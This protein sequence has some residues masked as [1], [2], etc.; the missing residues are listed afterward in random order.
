MSITQRKRWAQWLK[1]AWGCW[2]I[3][4]NLHWIW[5]PQNACYSIVFQLTKI[6]AFFLSV[7]FIQKIAATNR[8]RRDTFIGASCDGRLGH[9]VRSRASGRRIRSWLTHR[10]Q[11]MRSAAASTAGRQSWTITQCTTLYHKTLERGE[12][13]KKYTEPSSRIKSQSNNKSTQI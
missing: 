2:K 11:G 7:R 5:I 4:K 12:Y 1:F 10:C 3:R 6:S 9:T 8:T 13:T